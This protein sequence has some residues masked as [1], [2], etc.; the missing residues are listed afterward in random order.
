MGPGEHTC[1]RCQRL[2]L[3]CVV[4]KSLQTLLEDE[5]EWKV[6]I[7]G[8]MAQMHSAIVELLKVT[9]LPAIAAFDGRPLSAVSSHSA[10]NQ[11]TPSLNAELRADLQAHISPQSEKIS[12]G[13]QTVL[14]GMAMTRENSQEPQIPEG[15]AVVEAP[16]ASLFEVTKLRNLRSNLDGRKANISPMEG[17]FI[18]QGKI[19]EEE[20][21]TLFSHFKSSLNNYL[22]G[23]IALV[24]DSLK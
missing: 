9:N 16:M 12:P 15:E 8:Q 21:E 5:N 20:A 3:E 4:N 19:S 22:W 14:P 6:T 24:H 10:G 1:S 2:G 23:G 7:E 13:Q 11:I 18:S 17:D